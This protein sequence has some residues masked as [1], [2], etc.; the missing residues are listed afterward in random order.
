ML[1]PIS[2]IRRA[3]KE[4]LIFSLVAVLG[5]C[6]AQNVVRSAPG[7]DQTVYNSDLN[8]CQGSAAADGTADTIY[9]GLLGAAM[10][11]V[12][13]GRTGNIYGLVGGAA[14]GAVTAAG[15][16]AVETVR[17]YNDEVAQCLRAKGYRVT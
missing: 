3:Y 11:A 5:A 8:T 7:F 10:G 2:V 13:F 6:A 4:S 15:I 1:K 12:L 14:L 16:A 9:K 17:A